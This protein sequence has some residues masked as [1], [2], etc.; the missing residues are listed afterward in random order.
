[1]MQV[2]CPSGHRAHWHTKQKQNNSCG[3]A[4]VAI[5]MTCVNYNKLPG[6]TFE[7]DAL[8]SKQPTE[9]LNSLELVRLLIRNG[10]PA[11][12]VKM[13]EPYGTALR[14]TGGG[15]YEDFPILVQVLGLG[16]KGDLPHWIVLDGRVGDTDTF[17]ILDPGQDEGVLTRQ[18]IA[19]TGGGILS[20]KGGLQMAL[21][22]NSIRILG[23][24]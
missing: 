2:H 19:K 4:S 8:K 6:A 7:S 22:P 1:M 9:G 18:V 15:K 20:S 24:P 13:K 10:V 14:D 5:A 17:C 21:T 16:K 23:V 12:Y 11:E 3:A